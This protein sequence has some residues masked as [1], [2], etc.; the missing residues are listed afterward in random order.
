MV[1]TAQE[2]F[3]QSA[4]HLLKQNKQAMN[5]MTCRYRADD[6]CKCAVGGIIPD[7]LYDPV[8]EARAA[9]W[10]FET[11]VGENNHGRTGQ[12]RRTIAEY[13][14]FAN[15]RLLMQL[16]TI[17]DGVKPPF[18]KGELTLLAKDFGLSAVVLETFP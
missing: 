14:G 13:F 4:T 16:Q 15:Q 10:F 6:G 3:D 18:W 17:H 8:I 7:E 9:N 1:L 11:V 12:I 5:G 2:I